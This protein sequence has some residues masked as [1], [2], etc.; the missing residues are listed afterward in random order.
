M[1]KALTELLQRD[2]RIENE[3][4]IVGRFLPGMAV[5]AEPKMCRILQVPT[6]MSGISDR[7]L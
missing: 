7:F 2:A 1:R 5:M 6:T 3:M 4:N